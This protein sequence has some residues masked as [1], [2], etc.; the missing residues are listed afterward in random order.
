MINYFLYQVII[1]DMIIG[2]RFLLAFRVQLFFAG[3][4][5]V[6]VGGQFFRPSMRLSAAEFGCFRPFGS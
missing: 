5:K 3:D 2:L 6:A 1:D 4:L